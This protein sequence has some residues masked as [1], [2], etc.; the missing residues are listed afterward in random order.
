MH[1]HYPHTQGWEAGGLLQVK[2]Q[3]GLH[4]EHQA[5]QCYIARLCHKERKEERE[6]ETEGEGEGKGE[7]E[8]EREGGKIL[9]FA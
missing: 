4:K 8:G 5:S 9:L 2:G 6:R 7:K 1:A 3:P